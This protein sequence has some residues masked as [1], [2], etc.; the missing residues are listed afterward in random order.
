MS[1]SLKYSVKNSSVVCSHLQTAERLN[2]QKHVS[3]YFAFQTLFWKLISKDKSPVR[4]ALSIVTVAV[5]F[6]TA[7]F[8]LR[9]VNIDVYYR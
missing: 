4:L 3:F 1:P 2:I 5:V 7:V 9:Y 6:E 8:W